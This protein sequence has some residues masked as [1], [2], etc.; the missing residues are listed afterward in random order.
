[1]AHVPAAILLAREPLSSLRSSARFDWGPNSYDP[2][3]ALAIDDAFEE[4]SWRKLERAIRTLPPAR[5]THR[6]RYLAAFTQIT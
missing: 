5:Q 6:L 1:M 2:A 4:P 3:M